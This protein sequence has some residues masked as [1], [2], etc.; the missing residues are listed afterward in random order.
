MRLA[1][2]H[3]SSQTASHALCRLSLGAG[4]LW[5]RPV[6]GPHLLINCRYACTSSYILKARASVGGLA[7]GLTWTMTFIE[8]KSF[9]P[10]CDVIG[11]YGAF[12]IFASASLLAVV[13]ANVRLII[14][15]MSV[16]MFL[17]AVVFANV[18][19][20]T[21]MS[22]YICLLAVVFAIV[23]QITQMSVYLC[24]LLFVCLFVSS[25]I[26]QMS[27]F[28]CLITVISVNVRPKTRI[29]VFIR[30]LAIV[31]AK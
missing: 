8:T 10:L 18:R 1:A 28:M 4:G 25:P 21:R 23:R 12:W 14:I 13:F 26:T 9:L 3:D 31:Y 27:V 29:S 11:N 19:P 24:Y 6:N 20:I 7:T 16:F 15:G 5:T 17:L 30:L 2:S 22:V